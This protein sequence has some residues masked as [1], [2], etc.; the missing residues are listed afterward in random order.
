MQGVVH[1]ESRTRSKF[2]V[3]V[4]LATTETCVNFFSR[5]IPPE[6]PNEDPKKPYTERD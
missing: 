1:A 5:L 2:S 3:Y 6:I 4:R